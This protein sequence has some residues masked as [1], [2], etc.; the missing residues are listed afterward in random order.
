MYVNRTYRNN[1]A[2]GLISFRTCIRETDLFICVD[3]ESFRNELV[4]RVEK[5][6]M[7][8]RYDLENYIERDPDFKLTLNPHLILPGAP[9]IAQAM[10]AAANTAGVGPMAAVAG[11]FAEFVG[12]D[13][14]EVCNDVIV[15]NGGDIF[16]SS[17]QNRLAGVFA[18]DSLFTGQIAIEIPAATMPLGI[19]T[20][21]GTVGPSLSLGKADTAIIISGSTA[22]A[23]AAASAAGNVVQTKKD[24]KNGV[25][26]AKAI[27]GVLGA[28]IIKGDQLAAW[29]EFKI[30]RVQTS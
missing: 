18:G 5:K 2:K 17:T 24:V 13:L 4:Q 6:I 10:A 27:P 1:V 7:V 9:A 8:L 30:I 12:R 29:G 19:C 23:D 16:M 11:A 26:V 21:S 22:L 14:M 20:S 28:V 25:E 15:E 3:E